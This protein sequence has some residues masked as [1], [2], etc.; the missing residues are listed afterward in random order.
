MRPSTTRRRPRQGSRG[1]SSAPT[2]R[3]ASHIGCPPTFRTAGDSSHRREYTE[4]RPK[5]APARTQGPTPE[6]G[7]ALFVAKTTI[8]DGKSGLGATPPPSLSAQSGCASRNARRSDSAG[9]Q[10]FGEAAAADPRAGVERHRRERLVARQVAGRDSSEVPKLGTVVKRARSVGRDLDASG[11]RGPK[12]AA[13]VEVIDRGE[14]VVDGRRAAL[15]DGLEVGAV[16]AHR[17]SRPSAVAS[18]VLVEAGA[19]SHASA[20]GWF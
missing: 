17:Q 7:R 16:V 13:D 15:Q 20:S 5:P 10:V 6:P 14:R 11:A 3:P 2:R 1:R 4:V 9:L 19:E 18:G 8:N 12:A